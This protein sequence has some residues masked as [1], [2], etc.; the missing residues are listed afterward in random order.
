MK[1]HTD[2][3][4]EPTY[5]ILNK[6]PLSR[7]C[8][9]CHTNALRKVF[10]VKCSVSDPHAMWTSVQFPL[11]TMFQQISHEYHKLGARMSS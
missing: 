5:H 6:M 9:N 3:T 8:Y 10:Q 4:H 2:P 1:S 7:E 11:L